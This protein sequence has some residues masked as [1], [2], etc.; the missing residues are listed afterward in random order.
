[1]SEYSKVYGNNNMKI[2]FYTLIAIFICYVCYNTYYKYNSKQYNLNTNMQTKI[3]TGLA[4]GDY[5]KIVVAGGCFWCTEA[6]YNHAKGIISAVSGYADSNKPNPTY[7]E[8]S[9]GNVKARE[10]VEVIY[11]IKEVSTYDVLEKYFTHIDPTDSDGSFADRGYQYTPAIYYTNDNQKKVA[12]Q[13]V[14]TINES[15]KFDKEVAV[16]ILPYNNFYY[17]EEYHQ[18]YKDKNPV[19]YNVYRE[20]SGRNNYVKIHWQ[21]GSTTTRE[22]FSNVNSLN[23]EQ[24][25]ESINKTSISTISPWLNFTEEDK[26]LRLKALSDIQYKVT[27]QDGTE[28]PFSDGNYNDNHD[29]GIYVDIVSGEPLFYSEDKFDSGTGWPS[30]VRPINNDVVMLSTDKKLFTTRTEVR[31]KVANSHLGHVFDDG[32]SDRG[33]KRYCMNGAALKFIPYDDMDAAGYSSYK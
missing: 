1:M 13:V 18:D 24:N 9:S 27:Q 19:R 10:A 12:E 7:E 26:Q 22:I 5:E 21:D 3:E 28:R 33:G 17:A 30:F 11:N 32:P 8:V 2:I 25:V 29:K 6:E 15:H 16:Q 20:G 14:K 31:S 4:N 23:T